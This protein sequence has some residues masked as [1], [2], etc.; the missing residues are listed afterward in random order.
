MLVRWDF[1]GDEAEI[2]DALTG[3]LLLREQ[4]KQRH[5]HEIGLKLVGMTRA[6]FVQ[7]CCLF[8]EALDTV[9][10]TEDLRAA[11]T[12]LGIRG[13]G[14]GHQR[15]ESR[16]APRGGCSPAWGSTAGTTGSWP[17]ERW[18]GS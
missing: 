10:P 9:H 18:T 17:A 3:D 4:P 13:A 14:R 5:D 12:A 1:A 15:R 16:R 2:H 11:L 8:Q 7:V 6:E